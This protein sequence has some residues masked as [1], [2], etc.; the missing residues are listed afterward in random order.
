MR[1]FA[2]G[3]DA[4]SVLYFITDNAEDYCL[5]DE[6]HPDLAAEIEG[7]QSEVRHVKNLEALFSEADLGAMVAGLVADDTELS[8]FLARAME[9]REP[10]YELPTVEEIVRLAV[11]GAAEG[12]VN[13]EVKR[14]GF[15]SSGLDFTAI[16]I[17]SEIQS[18][19]VSYVECDEQS[20][21]WESFET[22]DD[23]TLLVRATVDANVS[24][25]GFVY[26]S[27]YV[28][29]DHGIVQLRMW[30]WND[31]MAHVSTTVHARLVF[32]LRVEVGV[33]VDDV[34]FESAEPLA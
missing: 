17:P 31:H 20:V 27:D 30:D 32:Q 13:E 8:R 34:E 12:L 10:D 5:G 6:L 29:V 21:D 1:Q 18:P 25:E 16:A 2:H 26:K 9:P 19:M 33:G 7:A 11:I 4:S 22:Y 3:L 23:T 24:L 15:A 14:E 28:V